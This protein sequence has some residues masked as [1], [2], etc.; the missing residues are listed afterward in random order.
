MRRS[1]TSWRAWRLDRLGRDAI[2][3]NKLFGWCID[4]GKSVVSCTEAIDLSTPVGRLIANVIGF[5]AEGELQ[6]IKER[7][8]ASRAKLRNLGRWP[9]GKPPFGYTARK[10]KDGWTLDIDPVASEVVARIVNDVIDGK[11]IAR[12]AAELTSEGV[13]TPAGSAPSP[14]LSCAP[15][16]ASWQATA[17][18]N[19]LRSKALRGYAHHKNETVRDDDG[20]PIQIAEPLVTL[21]EWDLLQA[22]LDQ[23]QARGRGRPPSPA[24]CRV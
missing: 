5:L 10:T 1:G 24:R 14:W 23:V 6:A 12:V 22:A 4:H 13:D 21:D 19:M 16:T 8:Q 18:R 2:R 17:I 3:L 9:G 20:R 15:E 11:P 7:Q